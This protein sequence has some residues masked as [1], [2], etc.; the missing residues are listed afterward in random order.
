MGD[1][2]ED[3]FCEACAYYL[4]KKVFTSAQVSSYK[5]TMEEC[6]VVHP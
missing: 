6:P 5:G 2:L 3:E 1:H 4:R